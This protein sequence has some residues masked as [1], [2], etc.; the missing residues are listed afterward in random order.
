MLSIFQL[1]CLPEIADNDEYLEVKFNDQSSTIVTSPVEPNVTQT[2]SGSV[3]SDT[4]QIG[5]SFNFS[6]E[7]D[8]LIEEAIVNYCVVISESG[9]GV[10]AEFTYDMNLTLIEVSMGLHIMLVG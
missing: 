9:R 10:S 6:Y 8:P 5:I 7:H 4:G 1:T 2:C 3:D